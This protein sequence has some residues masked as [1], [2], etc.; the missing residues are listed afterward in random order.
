MTICA[1]A[2]MASCENG[3]ENGKTAHLKVTS[4][5]LIEV[6]AAGDTVAV[7]YQLNKP[8]DGETVKT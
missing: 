3:G 5:T 4:S 7:T 2:F 8:I 6:D 1:M